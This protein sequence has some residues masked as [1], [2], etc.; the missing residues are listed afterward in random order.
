[1]RAETS[2]KHAERLMFFYVQFSSWFIVQIDV[3]T[4]LF[5]V[6]RSCTRPKMFKLMASQRNLKRKYDT[7]F[8]SGLTMQYDS[9][10]IMRNHVVSS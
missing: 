4:W 6:E 3:S 2:R 8:S 10:F 1:M 5:R 9:L 7:A